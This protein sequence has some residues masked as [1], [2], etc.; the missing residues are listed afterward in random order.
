MNC[1]CWVGALAGQKTLDSGGGSLQHGG[2]S[3]LTE[4]IQSDLTAAMKAR[5]QL[6]VSTL[7]MVL[8]AIKNAAVAG[9]EAIVLDDDQALAV[10]R[11]EAKKRVEAAEIYA[12]NG[13]PESAE[14]ERA[15]LAVIERYLPAAMSDEQLG[16][17]VAEEV[18]AA[19]AAGATGGKAM[20]AVIKAVRDRVGD[21]A[22]GSRIAAAVKSALA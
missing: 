1:S 18:A 22:D 3:T 8:A 6:D 11:S 20:G 10:V 14:K 5:Q 19:A 17:I 16:S 4:R 7:R 21:G 13:R 15:E 12:Q 9:D 2:M